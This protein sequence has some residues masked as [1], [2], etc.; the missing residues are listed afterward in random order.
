MADQGT[1]STQFNS[2]AQLRMWH[3]FAVLHVILIESGLPYDYALYRALAMNIEH[4]ASSLTLR[5]LLVIFVDLQIGAY[6]TIAK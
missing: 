6:R 2:T 5:G 1:D 4:Y 3:L